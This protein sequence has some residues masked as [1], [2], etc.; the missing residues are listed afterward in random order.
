[1]HHDVDMW[2]ISL[3]G[4]CVHVVLEETIETIFVS[5]DDEY[6]AKYK[7]AYEDKYLLTINCSIYLD[8]ESETEE[9]FK[10]LTEINFVQLKKMIRVGPS[11]LH[12]G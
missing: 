3:F 11:Y 12:V 2:K 1:M 6:K 9:S 4:L 5:S 10:L 8:I 7:Y